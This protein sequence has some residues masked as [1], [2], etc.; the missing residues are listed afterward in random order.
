MAVQQKRMDKVKMRG[1][2]MKKKVRMADIA[3]ALGVSTV[4][5]SKAIAGK[6]GVSEAVRSKIMVTAMEMGYPIK[7]AEYTNSENYPGLTVGVLIHER[8]VQKNESFYWN[9]YERVLD[10]LSAYGMF[11][12]FESFTHQGEQECTLPRLIQS[13][14]VQALVIIGSLSLA[15]LRM[16]RNT[17]LPAVHLD[18]YD[19]QTQLD[20]VISDGYYGTYQLTDYVI[21]KGHRDIAYLGRVGATGSITD[22]YYGYCRALQENN[23][24]LREEWVISD[25]GDQGHFQFL[26]P[27]KMPTAIVCNCDAVAYLLIRQ[28]NNLGYRIP[29]DLSVVCFDDYI[30]S[31]LASPRVT[32]YGVDVDAMAQICVKQLVRRLK[33]PNAKPVFRVVTGYLV[34]KES[35]KCLK[36]E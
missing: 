1:Y 31:E 20:T 4:T 26:M 29:E 24:P 35:V 22:R 27:E 3:N 25:R 9:M 5:V 28:L 11:G 15:Y 18:N 14:R 30:Y 32:A 8:F 13:G 2:G 17:G 19:P 34:E 7:A 10:K 6:D 12:M 36:T 23:I 16:L 21:Q 33:E